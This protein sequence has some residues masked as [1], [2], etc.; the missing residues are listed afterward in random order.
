MKFNTRSL[1]CAAMMLAPLSLFAATP[2]DTDA[3]ELEIRNKTSYPLNIFQGKWKGVVLPGDRFQ[4]KDYE[5]ATV[6]ISTSTP[7]AGI[8][9]VSLSKSKG[10]H[11]QTCV[12]ITGN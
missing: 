3:I 2:K 9:F 6:T 7:E 12:L 1:I 11:A 5:A 8:K 10:C 4:A